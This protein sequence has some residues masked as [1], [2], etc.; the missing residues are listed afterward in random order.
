MRSHF[1][2]LISPVGRSPGGFPPYLTSEHA[3]PSRSRQPKSCRLQSFQESSRKGAKAL[4]KKAKRL[5]FFLAFLAPL[6]LCVSF[7]LVLAGHRRLGLGVP[8]VVA[9][10]A[11][12]LR[13]DH[14]F[15]ELEPAVVRP[16]LE[17][18]LRL[19]FAVHLVH[20]IVE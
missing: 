13:R 17:E 19:L 6:R 10:V 15:G 4:R 2:P 8:L 16:A 14:V 3:H 20:E 7:L 5:L 12:L 11:P 1:S 9:D 18:D